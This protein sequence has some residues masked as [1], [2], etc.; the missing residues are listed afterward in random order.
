LQI[1][2]SPGGLSALNSLAH[3]VTKESSE[4]F[5]ESQFICGLAQ[6]HITVT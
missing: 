2:L 6:P 4:Q 3:R 5:E 1:R